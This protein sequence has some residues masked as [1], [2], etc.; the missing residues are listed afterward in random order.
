MW[1]W[2]RAIIL[3]V[4]WMT[5]IPCQA[6][7]LPF[8]V[9]GEPVV[10]GQGYDVPS[11]VMQGM[12]RVNIMLP[13][14]YDDPEQANAK[15]PVLY[16][17]DGGSGWQD[18]AHIASMVQ[19]GGTWGAN[20]PLIVVGIQSED[21]RAEFTQPSSDPAEIKDFPTS[22]DADTFRRFLVEELRPAIDSI[23]RTKGD[24][25]VMGE[26]LAALF[27]V[28]VALRHADDFSHY[29]AISP[30]LWWDGGNLSRDAR[31]LLSV[32]QQPE[33]SI[34]LSMAD[35]GGAMQQGMDRLVEA[36][37]A[38][39]SSSINWDYTAFPNERHATIYHPAA[40]QAIRSLFPPQATNDE[41]A[42]SE[43]GSQ[44]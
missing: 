7:E 30:S 41:E 34:W 40:T 2:W 19:Q 6:Q 13:T 29:I 24:N 28:D 27:V 12:R 36:L 20:V 15:Y 39:Q 10:I 17:L 3:A 44:G 35:E 1:M 43:I 9:A 23:Y 25:A 5:A 14:D 18:F 31:I 21:R 38:N 16:L 8:A 42:A 37:K 11:Q 26:S 22:G 32:S 4:S 33:R